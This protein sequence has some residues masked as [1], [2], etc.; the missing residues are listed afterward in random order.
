MSEE[1]KFKERLFERLLRPD[2][3]F[4][5]FSGF[6]IIMLTFM[7]ASYFKENIPAPIL[8]AILLSVILSVLSVVLSKK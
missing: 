1:Q 5:M 6:V 4:I 2:T 3:L 7:V 8:V